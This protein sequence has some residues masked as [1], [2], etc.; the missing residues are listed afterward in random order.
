[1]T[2]EKPDEKPAKG[3]GGRSGPK[4]TPTQREADRSIVAREILMGSSLREIAAMINNMDDRDYEISFQTIGNDAQAILQEWQDERKAYIDKMMDRELAKLDLIEREMWDAWK[5]SKEGRKST[6]IT[7]SKV[8]NGRVT[9]GD[10]AERK[11]EETTGDTRY[12]DKIQWCIEKRLSLLDLDSPKKL[13]VNLTNNIGVGNAI[14]YM[15]EVDIDK[16]IAR[17]ATRMAIHQGDDVVDIEPEEPGDDV[18][19]DPGDDDPPTAE[20]FGGDY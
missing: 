9:G 17:L 20:E 13:D 10:V 1:M 16:E 8:T 19:D 14:T 15:D 3:T 7:G 5:K 6:K 2:E 4:R 12:I 11:L 18:D